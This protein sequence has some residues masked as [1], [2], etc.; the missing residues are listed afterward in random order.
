MLRS[1]LRAEEKLVQSVIRAAVTFVLATA[2]VLTAVGCHNPTDPN[3]RTAELHGRV[4][5]SAGAPLQARLELW[6]GRFLSSNLSAAV[7]SD[8]SGE[9]VIRYRCRPPS[10]RSLY[11]SLEGYHMKFEEPSPAAWSI[12][13]VYTPQR[14]DFVLQAN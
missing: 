4:T 2:P 5:D 10:D 6:S 1:C 9:Y 7:T 3:A 13:C 11:V 8:A 12:E 14:F